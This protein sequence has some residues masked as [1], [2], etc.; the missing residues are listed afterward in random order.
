M[1]LLQGLGFRIANQVWANGLPKCYL[2]GKLGFTTEKA[3]ANRTE[4]L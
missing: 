4:G 2:F 3:E 1:Q